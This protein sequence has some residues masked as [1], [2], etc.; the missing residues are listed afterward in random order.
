MRAVFCLDRCSETHPDQEPFP[1]KAGAWGLCNP[2]AAE[3]GL[4]HIRK[5]PLPFRAHNGDVQVPLLLCRPAELRAELRHARAMETDLSHYT[6]LRRTKSGAVVSSRLPKP[7]YYRLRVFAGPTDDT[8]L[9]QVAD[10]LLFADTGCPDQEPFPDKSCVVGLKLSVAAK[11]GLERVKNASSVVRAKKGKVQLTVSLSRPSDLKVQLKKDAMEEDLRRYT[12]LQYTQ[13]G[14]MIRA[15]LPK[16]GYY[17]LRLFASLPDETT[18]SQAADFL[19]FAD[20]GCADQEPFPDKLGVWGFQNP[21]ATECGLKQVRNAAVRFTAKGGRIRVPVLL[22]GHVILKAHLK[23]ARSM[24][25]ELGKF[26]CLEYTEDGAMIHARLPKPGYYMLRVFAGDPKEAEMSH[27][28]DF[29]LS[30]KEGCVDSEPYPDE[31]GVIGLQIPTAVQCG[32]RKARNAPAS[33]TATK[34]EVEVPVSLSRYTEIKTQLNHSRSMRE[35]LSQFTFLQY[36]KDGATIR[37]RLPKPGYYRLR[38]FAAA[39]KEA[40]RLLHA[41]DFLL[42]ADKEHSDCKPFPRV[43]VLACQQ[44]AQLLQPLVGQ[45]PR[46]EPT[47]IRVSSP[48]TAVVKIDGKTLEKRNDGVW[49]AEVTPAKGQRDVIVLAAV[50]ENEVRLEGLYH[51]TVV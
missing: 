13:H 31:C 50:G 35:D 4:Q 25:E 39:P 48:N 12:F 42:H 29:L 34:G 1:E 17:R 47:L 16:P 30:A 38:V 27:A 51:F 28:A 26:V 6:F 11:C 43:C 23:H 14:A 45:L 18:M 22:K 7:G 20:K 46:G 41:A 9:Q 37:A 32:F 15:R 49:E 33:F 19:L 2:A 36:T 3:C 40:T 8:N 5:T 10:Y 44:R 24:Q 21:T